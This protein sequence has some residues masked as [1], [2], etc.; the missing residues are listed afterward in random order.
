MTER[1]G[2]YTVV[3]RLFLTPKRRARLERLI[4]DQRVDL[5]ELVSALVADRV[6]DL[7]DLE[8]AGPAGAIVVPTRLYLAPRL[9]E[10]VERIARAREVDLDIL[11]SQVVGGYLDALPE[12]P[13][14]PAR[15]TSAE[16]RRLRGELGRLRARRVAA[17]PAAPAWLAAY[18]AEIAAEIR[19]LEG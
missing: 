17:G 6:D 3:T 12:A 10:R 5:A 14:A 1:Q 9:R 13:P 2:A 15:D 19:R 16:L 8:C 11:V 7:A 4:R 18:I